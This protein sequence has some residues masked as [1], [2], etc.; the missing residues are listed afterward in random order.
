[1]ESVPHQPAKRLDHGPYEEYLDDLYRRKPGLRQYEIL[2]VIELE[3]RQSDSTAH[4][5]FH[6]LPY[7]QRL[8]V[9]RR[10]RGR[11]GFASAPGSHAK[12]RE[13]RD[14]YIEALLA[15]QPHLANSEI[16]R[17]II[18]AQHPYFAGLKPETIKG[19][20]AD[21]R[22]RYKDRM[23]SDVARRR[24]ASAGEGQCSS[25]GII[26]LDVPAVIA[27]DDLARL[28]L[29]EV[30]ELVTAYGSVVQK[31]FA[32]VIACKDAQLAAKDLACAQQIAAVKT[33]ESKKRIELD[34]ANRELS[35]ENKGLKVQI[36]QRIHLNRHRPLD[37]NLHMVVA[38]E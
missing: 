23:A 17:H 20:V 21:W 35:W 30:M 33:E 32:A 26:F 14:A 36:E 37:P 9:V 34:R 4:R 18:A 11:R 29:E 6:D 38:S 5:L 1:M 24:D 22:I 13:R 3:A 28:S 7:G 2:H 10:W 16:I 15:K 31:L 25:K 27:A 19:Y 8:N 12:L